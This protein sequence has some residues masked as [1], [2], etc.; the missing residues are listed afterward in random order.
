MNF[1]Y[2]NLD[3][4]SPKIIYFYRIYLGYI[5][6]PILSNNKDFY[7]LMINNTVKYRTE[8]YRYITLWNSP[9]D[10]RRENSSATY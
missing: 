9:F 3:F 2:F 7:K 1:Y 5:C 6:F 8:R 10:E 4:Y